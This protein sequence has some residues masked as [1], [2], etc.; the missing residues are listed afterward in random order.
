MNRPPARTA[1]NVHPELRQP[2]EN[3]RLKAAL[4]RIDAERVNAPE[5]AGTVFGEGRASEQDGERLMRDRDYAGAQVAFGRAA[6]LF[7]R[8]HE[9]TWQ[10]R[11]RRA[12]LAQVNTLPG[13]PSAR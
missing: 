12:D 3:L 6:Q 8:A 2:A 4:A 9:L 11:I 13:E 5:A 7:A 1:K 10:D